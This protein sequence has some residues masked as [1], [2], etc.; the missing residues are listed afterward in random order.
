MNYNLLKAKIVERGLKVEDFDS[1]LKESNDTI[2]DTFTV[3]S[4]RDQEAISVQVVG[5]GA[6]ANAEVNCTVKTT[7]P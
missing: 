2:T 6:G 4:F 7:S 3:T 5:D 1:K